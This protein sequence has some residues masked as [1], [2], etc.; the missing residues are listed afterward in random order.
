MLADNTDLSCVAAYA[1]HGHKWKVEDCDNSKRIACQIK[2][3]T[4]I[5][6]YCHITI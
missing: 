6:I 4:A 2:K 3:G 1:N 5:I